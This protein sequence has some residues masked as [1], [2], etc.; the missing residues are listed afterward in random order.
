MYNL[1][2]I[3]RFGCFS[4]IV[5]CMLIKCFKVKIKLKTHIV[6]DVLFVCIWIYR[7]MISVKNV[8]GYF[9]NAI[10]TIITFCN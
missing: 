6:A 4:V 3:F 10:N 7:E 5:V 2:V 1:F 9:I 8:Y